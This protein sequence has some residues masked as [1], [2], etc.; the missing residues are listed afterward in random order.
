[1]TPRN[2]NVISHSDIT[3]SSTSYFNLL[4]SSNCILSL[5]WYDTFHLIGTDN[6]KDLLR[7]FRQRFQ[8]NK[9]LIWS[10]NIHDVDYLIV[11]CYLEWKVDFAKFTIHL[12]EFQNNLTFVH[13]F[14]SF[15]F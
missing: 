6:I 14:S 4:I 7:L 2:R 11:V 15:C 9:I 13:L 10:F 5:A 1:M 8:H 3:V 12:F